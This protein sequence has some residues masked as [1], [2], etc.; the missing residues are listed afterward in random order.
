MVLLMAFA[1]VA[2]AGTALSPCVLPVLPAVLSAGVTG[3]RRRPLGVVTGLAVSF[4]FAVVALVYVIEALGLP[5]DLLRNVAIAVLAVFG[6]ALLVPPLG[7]RLEAWI[8][9]LVGAPRLSSGDGF[10]SGLVLG[11]S[12]GFVYAPCAGPILAGVITVSAAQDFTVGRLAVGLA[13]G[14]GSAAVLYLLV[15]GGRRIADRLSAYRGRVQMA[16]GAVMVAVAGLMAA[17]LDLEFQSAIADDLPSAL[18]NPTGEFEES[19][20]VA[21]QLAA[22]RAGHGASEAGAAEIEQGLELPVLGAAPEFTQTQRWFNTP[23]SKPLS[24]E[25]LTADDRVVLIDF[26]TYTCINC[27]RT[28]PYLREWDA[29]YRDDGLT[30]VG[31]H[32]PEFP[33][34]KDASNVEAAIAD[35]D[36]DY[37]VV[38]DN[39]LGTWNAFGNQYWPAKYLIDAKGRV[40]YTHFGEGSY[41]TTE[42]AIRTLLAE[43]GEARLGS[44]AEADAE[45]ADPG[46]TTPETYF[47]AARAEGFVNG[48]IN[49]GPRDFGGGPG[50]ARLPPDYLTYRGEWEI[51]LEAAT[52]R[53]GAAIDVRFGARRVF[54]VLGSPGRPREMRVLL[55]GRP[56]AD[57]L[58]GDD[59]EDGVATISEQRLYRLVELPRTERRTLTLEPEPGTS[60]YAFTFG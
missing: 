16:L 32:S 31:V 51:S 45:R 47:G 6:F 55:D 33:F 26:W 39:E 53:T 37:P 41:E 29:T 5:N 28:L 22:V 50:P 1:F 21:K 4:T 24:I 34:E 19:G 25:E 57:E 49:P 7:D 60:G 52:A 15:L 40:R 11:A 30:I 8:S 23:G 46:V 54:C 13:Y 36:L 38:Q 10:A 20:A 48:P 9:R 3:G 43:A 17:E 12:L 44:G 42:E 56:I 27:I 18:V 2:G 58:A 59:V 35:N 14:I